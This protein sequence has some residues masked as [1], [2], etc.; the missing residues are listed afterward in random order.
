MQEHEKG[1]A[2]RK[3]EEEKVGGE[4]LH[5]SVFWT[6]SVPYPRV[7]LI[8]H[9]PSGQFH[10]FIAEKK[11]KNKETKHLNRLD[12]LAYYQLLVS[13]LYTAKK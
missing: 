1:V 6:A 2:L 13:F 3:R 10:R 7:V 5:C 11:A 4:P 12:L 9:D 8:H